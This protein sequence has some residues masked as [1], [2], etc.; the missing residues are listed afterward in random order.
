M[1]TQYSEVLSRSCN[2]AFSDVLREAQEY[3]ANKEKVS[4]LGEGIKEIL[5]EEALFD[6]YVEKLTEGMNPEDEES[7]KTLMKNARIQTL[8]EATTAGIAPVA[9]L[10]FPTLRKLWART[11]LIKAVPT[12]VVK[13]NSFK[14]SHFKPYIIDDLG[15]KH[16]LPEALDDVDNEY[17]EKKSL[18]K[19]SITLP[20]EQY[21]MLADVGCSVATG[22]SIDLDFAVTEV[23]AEVDGEDIS[24]SI[25]RKVG[26]ADANAKLYIPVVY[27]N[28]DGE[29][30]Q[31]D[32]LFGFIDFD[33][34]LVDLVSMFSKV[35]S[36]K[37]RG[38]VASD[39]H[40]HSTNVSFD[41]TNE[42]FTIGTGEHF[43]ASLPLE[44]LQ[45]S[46]ATY[47]IDGTTE[48]VDIM[49]N[50]IA[51]KLDQ[52]IYKFIRNM[53][54]STNGQWQAEFDLR[55]PAQY[56]GSPKDWREEIK[57]VFDTLA[58]QIKKKFHSYNGYFVIVGSPVDMA[59]I[60]NINWTFDHNV[61]TQDGVNVD[62]NIG[63][64]SGNHIY[65]FVSSDI[66]TDGVMYML[67][68]P[69]TNN[70]LTMK[71]YPYTFNVVNNYVNTQRGNVPSI[72][73]TK[74]H[75]IEE[76]IPIVAEVLILNNNPSML[77]NLPR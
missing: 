42:D 36:V 68:I 18:S 24:I 4:I 12:E 22:D 45:D 13:S 41:V 9:S 43:E 72:M 63:A 14:V 66:C 10:T 3:F 16:Y 59:I 30:V 48:V 33:R 26:K 58:A 8:S 50:I 76:F 20:M 23:V 17:G 38:F 57:T 75:T 61:D 47:Q 6:D 29:E 54:R 51:Q 27:K 74:R 52:E 19:E 28:E 62:Y 77:K 55:P 67:F 37:I 2:D 40:N 60:P 73:M 65:K 1:A 11:G 71:Y 21:D 31:V 49:S 53:Y 5:S 34:G 7:M 15:N 56:A 32:R 64:M 25:P 46:M 44:F 35:K 70:F 39:A 69:T